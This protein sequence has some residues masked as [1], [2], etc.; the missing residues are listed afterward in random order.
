MGAA[1]ASC[2][3]WAIVVGG[4]L[5]FGAGAAAAVRV[6]IAC[7]ES[8]FFGSRHRIRSGMVIGIA[9]IASGI[10]IVV[11]MALA[12]ASVAYLRC[13]MKPGFDFP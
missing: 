10:A 6:G 5:L 8:D 3:R 4:F 2:A 7:I 12:T 1:G 9:S 11:L 13:P